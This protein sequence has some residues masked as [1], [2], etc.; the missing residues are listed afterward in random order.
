MCRSFLS[1][2]IDE[3]GDTRH[4]GR[5]NYGV[6]SV[7]LPRLAIQSNGDIEDFFRRLDIELDNCKE[8]LMIRYNVLK[9]VT[10]DQAPILYMEGAI[11]RMKEGEKIEPLLKGGYSTLSI[12]YIGIHNTLK[13]LLGESFIES[14]K[15]HEL[16]K[17]IMQHMREYT[18]KQKKETGLGFSVY[19]TP[20][21]AGSYKLCT[22]DV[23]DFGIIKGVNDNE[24]YENSYHYPSNV[25]VS[26]F[27][28]LSLESPYSE[29][30]SGG[31]ISFVELGD[32]TKNIKALEDI[33]R[34]SYDK[35]HFLGISTISDRCLECGYVGEISTIEDEC[36]KFM[37]PNCGNTDHKTMSVIRKLCGYLGSLSERP[38]V[39]GKMLEIKNRK[40]NLVQ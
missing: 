6:I 17:K 19:S 11:S 21:E 16:G 32:M 27:H 9:D 37:C 12:G 29:K 36:D 26:P 24:Y 13:A 3:F 35:T 5:F 15:A 1:E 8:L 30:A 14:D 4:A 23:K 39:R 31:A 10:A 33:V 22:N 18:D 20:F 34:Y 28:K 2:W 7:N 40:D 25:E 38:T